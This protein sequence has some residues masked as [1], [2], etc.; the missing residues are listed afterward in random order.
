MA[1]G[2]KAATLLL[3]LSACKAKACI[4]ANRAALI[5]WIGG[6]RIIAQLTVQEIN[7]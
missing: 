4:K 6:V 7:W 5:I 3:G 1:L 2:S